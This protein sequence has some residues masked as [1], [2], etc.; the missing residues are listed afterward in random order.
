MRL[1]LWIGWPMTVGQWPQ[2]SSLTKS[3]FEVSTN[4][5][6]LC[7]KILNLALALS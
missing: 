1:V 3:A 6:A 4:V 2:A 5:G 7:T